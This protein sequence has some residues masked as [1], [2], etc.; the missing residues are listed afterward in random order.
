MGPGLSANGRD[1]LV[2]ETVD[3]LP[4]KDNSVNAFDI[5]DYKLIAEYE[6]S[7]ADLT[8]LVCG[9]YL[10]LDA[11]FNAAVWGTSVGVP[12]VI[13]AGIPIWWWIRKAR[14]WGVYDS[15]VARSAEFWG[16]HL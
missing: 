11:A 6:S 16:K 10:R 2:T 7:E 13:P 14:E 8:E 12:V 9:A 15:V 5:R 1:E 3:I 4:S